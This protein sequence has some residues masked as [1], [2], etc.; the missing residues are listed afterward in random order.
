M[1]L[2]CLCGKIKILTLEE[3]AGKTLK[4]V[5]GWDMLRIKVDKKIKWTLLCPDCLN[6][7]KNKEASNG[8][9]E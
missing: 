3:T 1:K 5:C 8:K 2:T 9:D 7:Y 4:N 6:S